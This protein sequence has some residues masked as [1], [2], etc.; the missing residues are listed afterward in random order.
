MVTWLHRTPKSLWLIEVDPRRGASISLR[1]LKLPV[2]PHTLLLVNP[3]FHIRRPYPVM[4]QPGET[5]R[6]RLDF[7]E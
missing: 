4:T 3:E 7:A 6:K 1:P 2:G 5:L